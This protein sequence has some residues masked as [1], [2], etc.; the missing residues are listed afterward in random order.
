VRVV[1]VG[2]GLSGLFT[3]SELLARGIDDVVVVD[4]GSGPGGVVRTIERD[5]FTL[6]SAVG[7][8]TLP[9]PHLTPILH[10]IGV[11]V[12]M[13]DPSAS[14]RHVFSGD[15]LLA[16][17]ASPAAILA[18]ILPVRSK[19]RAL[20]EPFVSSRHE[21]GDETLDGFCRRRF[22]DKAG[23]MMAWLAASGVFA[24]DPS[25]LS[26]RAA[27][28]VLCHLEDDAGSVI[29]GG[30]RRRRER[31]ARVDRGSAHLPVRGM[32]AVAQAV[33]HQLGERYRG[34]FEVRSV[35]RN[36]SSWAV[37]GSERLTAD[38]VV[39][40]CRPDLAA[41]LVHGDLASTLGRTATAPV[42][43]VGLGGTTHPYP[44]P[45]GFGA[46]TGPDSALVSLG[47]MFESSYAPQRAPTGS[48]LVKVIAG[49]ARR[50]EVVEWD[51]QR[52]AEQVCAEVSRVVGHDLMP[53]FVEVV[54]HQPGIPQYEVGHGAWL[55][56]IDGLLSDLPGLHVTGWGYRGVGVSHL[57]S[58]A[59]AVARRLAGVP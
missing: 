15:R 49:G 45:A 57:A 10:R 35:S 18:P 32:S 54:R 33:I 11:E 50:P 59:V 48:W 41:R 44:L 6:E 5:G 7:S 25:R 37:D 8:L 12:V 2:G 42:V 26:A 47:M 40:S 4:E 31:P 3:A 23:E 36:R 55:R 52:L 14:L 34:G 30:L 38:A 22:G 28:P 21:A 46:L 19:L 9:H 27:F 29:R 13:A 56:A 51:D 58:D 1:V 17:P 24:G 53:E 43:V 16:I 39:I 20:A